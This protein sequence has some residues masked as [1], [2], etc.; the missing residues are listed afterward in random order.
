MK[1]VYI[2][3]TAALLSTWTQ[4]QQDSKFI[5][6]HSVI[7]EIVNHPSKTRVDS[8]ISTGTLRVMDPP[9]EYILRVKE[10]AV[11]SGDST[12][13]SET[14]IGIIAIALSQF[15][16]N[17]ELILVSSDF[18]LLNTA[19]HLE[20]P[21]HDLTGKMSEQRVWSYFCPACKHREE[22]PTTNLECPVCGTEMLRRTT[23]R[24]KMKKTE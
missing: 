2:L 3:D 20:I 12:N 14:D 18:A 7:D 23:K 5:T 24:K 10:G 21:I 8:L 16:E 22:I 15:E 1:Q 13:L 9:E 17:N 11:E 19:A 4:T 6:S